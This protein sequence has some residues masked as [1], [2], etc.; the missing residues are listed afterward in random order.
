MPYSFAI[1]ISVG[2]ANT[3]VENAVAKTAH[4][5]KRAW[6]VADD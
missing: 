4:T 1:V 2:S 5:T 3:E 6:K